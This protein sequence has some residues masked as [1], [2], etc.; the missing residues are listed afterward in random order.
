M[1]RF[2]HKSVASLAV[3]AAL[4][5]SATHLTAQATKDTKVLRDLELE[6]LREAEAVQAKPLEYHHTARIQPG[7]VE[8]GIAKTISPREQPLGAIAPTSATT[9]FEHNTGA[10]P[11][12]ERASSPD[13]ALL[14]APA[15]ELPAPPQPEDPN[16]E[17]AAS[18]L[19]AV[20]PD[21]VAAPLPLEEA[22]ASPA[23]STAEP[24]PPQDAVEASVEPA[25]PVLEPGSATA[26][27][28]QALANHPSPISVSRSFGRIVKQKGATTSPR[29]LGPQLTASVGL[30]PQAPMLPSPGATSAPLDPPGR[31]LDGS[32]TSAALLR[33][34]EAPEAAQ[35]LAQ[36]SATPRYVERPW[37]YISVGGNFGLNEGKTELSD[38]A[39]A[40]NSK[41]GFLPYLSVRPAALLGDRATFLLP[42]TYDL[43]I[44]QSDPFRPATFVPY[45]GG[46]LVV[47]THDGYNF[48]PL[49]SGGLDVRVSESIVIN[50]GINAG[51]L[52]DSTDIGLTIGVGY[53]FPTNF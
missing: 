30:R 49:I 18:K 10:L 27:H 38:T 24:P 7:T 19:E 52:R 28:L 26:S 2:P 25:G 51:F 12:L 36:R 42:V 13:E 44:G 43:A 17:L 48:G 31:A 1:S 50:T 41:I 22:A 6:P 32:A 47:T 21:Y 33:K 39:F 8:L 16:L 20:K 5:A 37:S 11:A 35:I 14:A 34:P 45:L 23:V 9:R 29:A 3:L 40:I 46:G 53:I 4:T 15:V